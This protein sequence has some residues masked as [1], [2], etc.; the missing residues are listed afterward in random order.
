MF[1]KR[2]IGN[3]IWVYLAIDGQWNPS[4]GRRDARDY[5]AESVGDQLNQVEIEHGAKWECEI[6]PD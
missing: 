6:C 1:I 3:S 5:D 2:Q 4:P